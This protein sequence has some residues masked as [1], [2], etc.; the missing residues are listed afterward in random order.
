MHIT[1]LGI[2]FPFIIITVISIIGYLLKKSF[3]N[4]SK[5]LQGLAL[6]SQ[7]TDPEGEISVQVI[8][9]A[10]YIPKLIYS[11]EEK[12]V[13][14]KI[15]FTKAFGVSLDDS[16]K[17]QDL[18]MVDCET[19]KFRE[20]IIISGHDISK[21]ILYSELSGNKVSLE[22]NDFNRVFWVYARYTDRPF[23]TLS[24][25]DM[26]KLLYMKDQLKDVT[27]EIHKNK[28]LLYFESTELDKEVL[29]RVAEA[30]VESF[31]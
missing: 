9:K 10:K 6:R 1:P 7:V 2:I 16:K 15:F 3:K 23:Y 19:S 12:G 26:E 18:Y 22:A 21:S 20:D 28:I 5:I 17:E 14:Y 24:P 25:E 31:R 13:K 29:L 11:S 27:I 4:P 30:V 8:G